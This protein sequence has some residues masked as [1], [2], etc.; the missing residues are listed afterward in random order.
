MK[1]LYL[2]G[3]TMGVGKTAVSQVLKKNLKNAVY[4]DGDN[5][6]DADPFQVTDETKAMVLDNI[7]Y[8]LNNFLRC[9]AYENVLFSWVM[10]EQNII[11][12][13]SNGLDKRGCTVKCISLMADPE[14]SRRRLEGDILRGLRTEDVIQRSMERLTRFHS[15]QT[16]KID[17]S[18]KSVREV[19]EEIEQLS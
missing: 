16:V 3:G 14:T 15:L 10:H 7:C 6:W 8:L 13:I 11:D 12:R 1:T 17:T 9:S 4:L 2:I 18:G 19:A 5:C